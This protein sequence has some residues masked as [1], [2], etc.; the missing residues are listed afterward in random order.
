MFKYGLYRF[1]ALVVRVAYLVSLYS[2][3]YLMFARAGVT[4][5]SMGEVFTVTI[6]AAVLLHEFLQQSAFISLFRQFMRNQDNDDLK[7]QVLFHG[8]VMLALTTFDA[9]CVWQ[10]SPAALV[11]PA[12]FFTSSLLVEADEDAGGLLARQAHAM[13][14]QTTRTTVGQ[15]RSRM[16]RARKLAIN[17]APVAAALMR[18]AG[19]EADAK[20]ITIIDDA[21]T[22]AERTHSI[23]M[24]EHGWVWHLFHRS[25]PSA[26]PTYAAALDLDMLPMHT[27]IPLPVPQT[28]PNGWYP[29]GGGTPLSSPVRT[30]GE[31][32]FLRADT[33]PSVAALSGVR[34]SRS[35]E[36]RAAQE[37]LREERIAAI[38]RWL[39]SARA[40]GRAL[41]VR[42]VLSRLE[43]MEP[44]KKLSESYV[45]SL[46]RLAEERI[47]ARN[48][49]AVAADASQVAQ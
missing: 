6:A 48:A 22:A 21:L 5:S 46:M 30:P 11:L 42:T 19:N 12:L 32:G 41:S 20:R 37:T 43:R 15:W 28:P 31:P 45:Q 49:Y 4:E 27:G 26:T 16:R 1:L 18:D 35:E 8:G 34:T 47:K 13:Q 24:R 17:L 39:D 14:M 29:T 36:R 33:L 25:Q 38:V 10:L 7:R 2:G 40:S 9:Y 44:R 23:P 3:V